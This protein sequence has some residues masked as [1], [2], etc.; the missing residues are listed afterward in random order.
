MHWAQCW[1]LPRRSQMTPLKK[2]EE[3]MGTCKKVSDR[4]T[5]LRLAP[6]CITMLGVKIMMAGASGVPERKDVEEMIHG[7]EPSTG[8]L[9]RWMVIPFNPW[10]IILYRYNM[11]ISMNVYECVSLSP[12]YPSFQCHQG[13]GGFRVFCKGCS[14]CS[15][16]MRDWLSLNPDFPV[17]FPLAPQAGF[18]LTLNDSFSAGMAEIRDNCITDSLQVRCWNGTP[19]RPGHVRDVVGSSHHKLSRLIANWVR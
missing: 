4:V 17:R 3:F 11:G 9:E 13:Y 18:S 10:Q 7:S 1:H 2:C 16:D 8:A 5:C 14:L 12:L 19:W 15:L 6:C